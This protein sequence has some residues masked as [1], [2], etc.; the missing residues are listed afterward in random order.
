MEVLTRLVLVVTTTGGIRL[1][2]SE[3]TL[4]KPN[5]TLR[6]SKAPTPAQIRR[7]KQQQSKERTE[8]MADDAYAK[9]YRHAQVAIARQKAKQQAMRDAG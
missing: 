3:S 7:Q 8:R 2:S 4:A 1:V 6:Q 9:A 5:R